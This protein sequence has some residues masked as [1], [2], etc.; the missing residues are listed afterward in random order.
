MDGLIEIPSTSTITL[1]RKRMHH[2]NIDNNIDEMKS[3]KLNNT[4]TPDLNC[5]T[6]LN[7]LRHNSAG[8]SC[9]NDVNEISDLRHTSLSNILKNNMEL[10]K[11]A[12]PNG[13]NNNNIGS[14]LI[15]NETAKDSEEQ[16][17][18]LM[19]DEQNSSIHDEDDV[20]FFFVYLLLFYIQFYD[21]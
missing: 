15:G 1:K 13:D 12:S 9:T 6:N 18:Q 7:F 10:C 19:D 2:N 16:F 5:K 17:Q 20:S 4:F 8:I 14:D 11:S 21:Q 3:L